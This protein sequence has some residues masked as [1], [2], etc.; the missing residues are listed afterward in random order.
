MFELGVIAG[1]LG[2][3]LAD[4]HQMV[5]LFYSLAAGFLSLFLFLHGMMLPGLVA[6]F[7]AAG[8]GV[9]LLLFGGGLVET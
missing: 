3:M 6:L 8:G 4:S 9:A 2:V 1:V 7:S 5:A